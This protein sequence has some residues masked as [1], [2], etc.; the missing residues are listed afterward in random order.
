MS[1]QQPAPVRSQSW[2]PGLY[3]PVSHIRGI[4]FFADQRRGGVRVAK[5]TIHGTAAEL[6]AL[7][8]Q[9]L[10]AADRLEAPEA[11]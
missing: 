5:T 6:R 8:A 4:E 7:A 3:V 11:A 10:R 9:I 2:F 1:V